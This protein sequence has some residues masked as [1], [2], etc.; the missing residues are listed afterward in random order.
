MTRQGF[1]PTSVNYITCEHWQRDEHGYPEHNG[2]DNNES[3]T[4]TENTDRLSILLLC[5]TCYAVI[6]DH[7]L[8]AMVQEALENVLAETF[9]SAIKKAKGNFAHIPYGI[10]SK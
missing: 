10:V 6:R 8:T 5:P 4:L 9:G 2:F 7:V 1:E 3:I